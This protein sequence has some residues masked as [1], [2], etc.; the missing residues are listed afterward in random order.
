M[1]TFGQ[2]FMAVSVPS[3]I[4]LVGILLN[5][6]EVKEVAKELKEFRIQNAKDMGEVK[7]RLAVLETKLNITPAAKDVAA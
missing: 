4:A 6:S 3:L 7:T 5:R 1:I 2:L